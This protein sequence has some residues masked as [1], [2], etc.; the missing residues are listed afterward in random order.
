M[1]TTRTATATWNGTLLE[2]SGE[3]TSFE[4]GAIGTLPV[5]WPLGGTRRVNLS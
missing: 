4:S 5:S 1:M 2:G 3:I